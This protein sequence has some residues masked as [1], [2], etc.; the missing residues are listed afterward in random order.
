MA[1]HGSDSERRLRSKN[2]W[3][4]IRTV[5]Q[6]ALLVVVVALAARAIL[7]P[8]QYTPVTQDPA[9][10]NASETEWTQNQ[11]GEEQ[12]QAG[13]AGR[14]GFIAISYNGLTRSD[15]LD[16][17]IVTQEA[18]EEQMA[19]LHASGYVTITQQDVLDYYLY[20]SALPEKAMLLIFEDGIFNTATLAQPSLEKYNYIATACTYAQ[21]LSDANSKFITTANMKEL[22]G[23]S[24]WELGSNGYR[25]SYINIFDRYGNYFGHLTTDEYVL[26]HDWLRRDY[27]HY[28]MDFLRD[29]DRLRQET[30]EQMQERIAYDYEQ[31][32]DIYSAEL[33][34]VPSLYILMHSNTG[35]FGNDPLVSDKNREMLTQV[36]A[37]NFNRQGSCL[38]TLDSSVYDLTRLQSRHYFST[39]HLLMRIWD[40]TGDDVAFVV[41]DEQE[42]EKWYVDEGVAEFRGN[43]IILTTQPYAQGRMTLKTG[44]MDD[45]DMTVTL[46]GNVVGR[47]SVCLR[48]DRELSRGVEVALENN[49]LVVRDLTGGGEE[50]F[51]QNLF[52]FD[53]GPFISEQEDEREGLIALQEA[54][55]QWDD[56]PERVK[57]ARQEL[58]RLQATTAISLEEGGTPYVPELDISDRDS[59]KLRIQLSG[60]R[61]SIW[62]D[63]QPVVER[64]A[65]SERGRGSVA[66]VAEVWKETERFSQTNL[67]DDV[68]D[69]V[70]I[71]PVIRDLDDEKSIFYQYTLQGTQAM[72]Y[73]FQNV[74]GNIL[75]FF[76][77]HF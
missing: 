44:L 43:E 70:F 48:T 56:D 6:A 34:Y 39:N 41:G 55:L 64:L 36:F 9:Y 24:Y 63:D 50:L 2:R 31:M 30:V 69:A 76:V 21:N 20:H 72:E 52:T 67:Y 59:R 42:A 65:I 61:L 33:G 71:D 37:M 46:Q 13:S 77:E 17:A 45:L 38:N 1:E 27:N 75:D 54:I 57:E 32:R 66:L 53:G 74:I 8:N 18:F 35:A 62:L 5:L 60:T 3:K 4:A 47:Q 73:T 68:Y 22:L 16:S 40:D 23:N 7:F 10:L 15:S 58:A 19:A 51:R 26:I 12:T 49:E 28:L 25:L 29:E 14:S 11:D